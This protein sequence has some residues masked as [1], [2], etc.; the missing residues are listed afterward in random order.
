MQLRFPRPLGPGD[1]IGVTSPSSGVGDQHRGRFEFAVGWLRQR[2]YLVEIGGCMDGASHVSAPAQD[3]AEELMRMLLAPDIRAVIPPWGGETAIDLLPH[4]DFDALEQ[5]EPTWFVGFSDISTLLTPITL[6]SGWATLHGGSLMDTPYEV[7]G[8]LS[9]WLDVATA[10]AGAVI[11]QSSANVHR[12][13]GRDDWSLDSATTTRSWNGTG[14]WRRL[15]SGTTSID[16]TGR[17]IGGCID[18][19]ANIAGTRFGNTRSL[20]GEAGT[21]PTITYLEAAEDNAFAIC[22]FLHG[23]RL[24]GFFDGAAAVMIGRTTAPDAA[25]LTQDEA[26]LDALSPLGIPIVADVE[27]GHVPPQ[28][29]IVNGANARLVHGDDD[30]YLEQSLS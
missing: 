13:R 7:P 26:V 5:A 6:L 29:A 30:S 18:T 28:M 23:M 12:A 1:R 20:R 17:L 3:R 22:R 14:T 16:V 25:S 11:R 8:T 21:E 2:G 19:L 24:A 10:P 4:L 9:S 27:F 15:D